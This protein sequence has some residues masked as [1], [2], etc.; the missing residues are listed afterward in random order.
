MNTG[1]YLGLMA[2]MNVFWDRSSRSSF[3]QKPHQSEPENTMKMR[4]P[5]FLAI[6]LAA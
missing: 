1:T 2:S 3:R 5:D 6:F 4:F